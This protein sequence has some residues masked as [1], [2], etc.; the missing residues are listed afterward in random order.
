MVTPRTGPLAAYIEKNAPRVKVLR[1]ASCEESLAR[2]VEGKADA[3]AVAV[4]KGTRADVLAR[5]DQASPPCP[6]PAA[7]AAGTR[8]AGICNNRHA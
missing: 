5:L 3:A 4:A 8:R 1:T 7:D 2:L 6:R